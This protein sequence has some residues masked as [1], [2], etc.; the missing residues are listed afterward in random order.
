MKNILILIII[1]SFLVSCEKKYNYICTDRVYDNN[2]NL[3]YKS[4]PYYK[5]MNDREWNIY[6]AEKKTKTTTTG[7]CKQ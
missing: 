6:L 7:C 4:E 5:Q 2:R 1:S 3:I